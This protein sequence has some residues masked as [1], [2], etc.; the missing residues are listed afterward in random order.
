[1]TRAEPEYLRAALSGG[2]GET[3]IASSHALWQPSAKVAARYLAP[4]LARIDASTHSA[5]GADSPGLLA[6]D[7]E[8]RDVRPH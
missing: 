2:Q 5:L 4:Y 1:M 6:V 3:S 7:V 8:L